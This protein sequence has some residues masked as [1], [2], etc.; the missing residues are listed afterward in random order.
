MKDPE[1]HK[2]ILQVQFY[3]AILGGDVMALAWKA[4]GKAGYPLKSVDMETAKCS[5]EEEIVAKMKKG[6]LPCIPEYEIKLSF[7]DYLKGFIQS[8]IEY[9]SYYNL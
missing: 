9:V 7:D 5:Y 1:E 4:F 6:C 8:R 3:E 2:G